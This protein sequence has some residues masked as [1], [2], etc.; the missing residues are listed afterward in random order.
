MLKANFKITETGGSGVVQLQGSVDGALWMQIGQPLTLSAGHL[1]VDDT[2]DVI[3]DTATFLPGQTY[4]FRLV[5][6]AGSPVSNI[7]T[8]TIHAIKSVTAGEGIIDVTDH[9]SGSFTFDLHAAPA[10]LQA[11]VHAT[12]TGYDY[13]IDFWHLLAATP[14][15]SATNVT[16]DQSISASGHT[17]GIYVAQVTYK[18]SDGTGFTVS[19]LTK[20]DNT[21]TVVLDIQINGCTISNISGLQLNSQAHIIQ[22]GC[23]Y[24]IL[25]AALDPND[26]DHPTIAAG[27]TNATD[28][29]LLTLPVTT[30]Y[31]VYL[32]T[33]DSA[34]SDH[35]DHDFFPFYNVTIP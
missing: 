24:E 19:R 22:T 30:V 26:P 12:L 32:L 28:T 14:I 18:F 15:D 34:I 3:I 33:W 9:G 17:D 7:Q 23:N 29:V 8:V 6:M 21:G 31:V 10:T 5:D 4:Q 20:V 27:P 2:T 16:A 35:F 13:N 11:P 25:Y 1:T